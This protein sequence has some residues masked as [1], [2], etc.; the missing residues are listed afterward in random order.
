MPAFDTQ[1][2]L[3]DDRVRLRPLREADRPAVRA[4]AADPLTW[5][6]HNDTGRYGPSFERYFEDNLASGGGL[7]IEDARSGEVIGLTRLQLLTGV[8]DAVEV[9]WTFLRRDRWG[10]GDNRSAK[11][12]LVDY[13]A[14]HG[15]RVLL[16]I[17]EHNLRSRRAAE[18]LGGRLV[19]EGDPTG[20]L[21]TKPARVVY[22][23][24]Q[25]LAPSE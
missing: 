12:L 5:Q 7:A 15:R 8:D 18:K 14:T 2:S 4:A 19:G 9:G 21:P 11:R 25:R 16:F 13:A 1:P 17:Y 6:Q 24:P 22:V 10:T 23:L 20:W 3:V